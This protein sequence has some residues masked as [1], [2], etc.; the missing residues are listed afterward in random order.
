MSFNKYSEIAFIN[1]IGNDKCVG[2]HMALRVSG[3]RRRWL[4]PVGRLLGLRRC[5]SMGSLEETERT[6]VR[7]GVPCPPV[8]PPLSPL[9]SQALTTLSQTPILV[10]P[11]KSDEAHLEQH[12]D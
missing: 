12:A 10:F 9:S 11:P 8:S 5:N 6:E 4:R 7:P 1:D 3:G 2:A